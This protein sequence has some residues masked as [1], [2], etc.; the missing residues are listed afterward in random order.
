MSPA[1][2][3]CAT[4]LVNSIHKGVKLYDID[5]SIGFRQTSCSHCN[6]ATTCGLELNNVKRYEWAVKEI[7]A[8]ES[9]GNVIPRDARLQLRTTKR[10]DEDN[11][12]KTNTNQSRKKTGTRCGELDWSKEERLGIVWDTV[13]QPSTAWYLRSIVGK[14]A[15]QSDSK[16]TGDVHY[17]P[18]ASHKCPLL[19]ITVPSPGCTS[20]WK[21]SNG[22]RSPSMLIYPS[23][24][25][26][27]M[28]R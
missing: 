28:M 18:L 5:I 22:T 13:H 21:P 3:R 19:L 24:C 26:L 1:R 25:I 15:K 16:E 10:Y 23:S 11:S 14:Q 9:S 20:T 7:C 27:G 2:F 8:S 12:E 4:Q 17:T 6:T